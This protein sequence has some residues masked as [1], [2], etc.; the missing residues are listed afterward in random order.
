MPELTVSEQILNARPDS[1][2]KEQIRQLLVQQFNQSY[3]SE[4]LNG[5]VGFCFYFNYVL[6]ISSNK[7]DEIY[8]YQQLGYE[9][10][11]PDSFLKSMNLHSHLVPSYWHTWIKES[12]LD[13]IRKELSQS[14]NFNRLKVKYN[15]NENQFYW[16]WGSN[17]KIT[18][19]MNNSFVF[20]GII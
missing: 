17:K 19:R 8:S 20:D 6:I 5:Q 11:L 1:F 9:L 10:M 3:K 12:H 4:T 16:D 13:L 14:L 15:F 7:N 2:I 18:L